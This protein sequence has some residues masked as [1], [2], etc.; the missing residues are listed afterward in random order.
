MSEGK[1]LKTP[2]FYGISTRGDNPICTLKRNE[3]VIDNI[4]SMSAK[5][6][7]SRGCSGVYEGFYLRFPQNKYSSF[8]KTKSLFFL[9]F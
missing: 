6:S 1:A 9:I 4:L 8:D 7:V 5:P 2:T 3:K